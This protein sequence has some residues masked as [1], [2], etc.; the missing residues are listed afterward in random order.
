MC[1][2]EDGSAA[3]R[4]E[5]SQRPVDADDPDY[6]TLQRL[7]VH[8]LHTFVDLYVAFVTFGLY[9]FTFETLVLCILSVGSVTF[10]SRWYSYAGEL[11]SAGTPGRS[12]SR[13]AAASAALPQSRAGLTR[14]LPL[15]RF[16]DERLSANINW[17][18]FSFAVVFPLT[19]SLARS[20]PLAGLSSAA[21]AHAA[22]RACEYAQPDALPFPACA[23]AERGVQAARACARAARADEG[24]ARGCAAAFELSLTRPRAEQRAQYL[25]GTPR[26]ELGHQRRPQRRSARA[27]GGVCAARCGIGPA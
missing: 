6:G 21:R 22:N 14:G 16:T 11:R 13:E 8:A 27:S 12:A 20:G 23:R 2:G 25:H 19:F 15:R 5:L 24:A 26:L 4:P 18:F 7:A 1:D 9:L 3:P 10:Y 17:T